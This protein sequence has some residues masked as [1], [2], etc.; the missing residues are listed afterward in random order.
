MQGLSALYVSYDTFSWKKR[1]TEIN[2]VNYTP[3]GNAKMMD[4]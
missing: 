1:I 3:K 4:G 2:T